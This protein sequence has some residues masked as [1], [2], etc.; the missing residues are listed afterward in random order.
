[1]VAGPAPWPP[2]ECFKEAAMVLENTLT[3]AGTLRDPRLYVACPIRERQQPKAAYL[4][5]CAAGGVSPAGQQAALEELTAA[6]LVA[7]PFARAARQREPANPDR[8]FHEIVA[9][10]RNHGNAMS[11]PAVH[12]RW[13]GPAG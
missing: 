6:L 4:L 10:T 5:H 9:R 12:L 13:P 7:V 2:K 11:R 8:R 3:Q 1:M